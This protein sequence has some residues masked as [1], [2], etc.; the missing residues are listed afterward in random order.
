MPRT[1]VCKWKGC[2]TILSE[3]ANKPCK[4]KANDGYCLFHK[5]KLIDKKIDYFDNKKALILQHKLQAS[6]R[7]RQ[8]SKWDSNLKKVYYTHLGFDKG[9]WTVLVKKVKYVSGVIRTYAIFVKT[10][11]RGRKIQPKEI[12]SGKRILELL[13][14]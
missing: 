10:L 12:V 4:H 8:L 13:D 9:L 6:H 1:R 11:T 7:W 5:R 2:I 14:L 3:V